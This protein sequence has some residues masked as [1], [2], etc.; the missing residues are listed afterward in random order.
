MTADAFQSKSVGIFTHLSYMLVYIDDITIISYT[1]FNKHPVK[2]EQMLDILC[3]S[4][5][6]VNPAR[7]IWTKHEID[8]LSFILT[9]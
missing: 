4:E 7:Y 2:I 6:Q 1:T 9:T 5:I 8:Y 3:K